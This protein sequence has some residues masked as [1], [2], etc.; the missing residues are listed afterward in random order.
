[1]VNENTK[2]YTLNSQPSTLNLLPPFREEALHEVGAV[3][4]QYASGNF[5]LGVQRLWC[6]AAIASLVVG[7]AIDQ[8][9]QLC[10]SQCS[11]AHDARLYGDI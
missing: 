9:P 6:K 10:P 2:H 11:G 3:A 7:C 4:L 1:M 5:G 8:A